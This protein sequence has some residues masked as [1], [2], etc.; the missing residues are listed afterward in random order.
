MLLIACSN[1][2][3]LV[4][5]MNARAPEG[6]GRAAVRLVRGA[7]TLIG[8]VMVESLLLA[9]AGA[10]LGL[11]LSVMSTRAMLGMLPAGG[12]LLMLLPLLFCRFS[13]S[14]LA[15]RFARAR[16]SSGSRRPRKQPGWIFSRRLKQDAGGAQASRGDPSLRGAVPVTAGSGRLFLQVPRQL[17]ANR[18][19]P[20]GLEK[21]ATFPLESSQERLHGSGLC[22]KTMCG[23]I[24][25]DTRRD[26]SHAR[27]DTVP[28][29]ARRRH[30]ISEWGGIG[31]RSGEEHGGG[32]RRRGSWLLG[33]HGNSTLGWAPNQQ[34]RDRFDFSEG[35]RYPTRASSIAASR[36]AFFPMRAPWE[37]TLALATGRK[38]WGLKS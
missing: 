36:N 28:S 38:S 15:S 18:D 33:C 25:K 35:G 31:P 10:L 26:V 7:G 11:A 3:S 20:V 17:E 16:C 24:A 34:D 32:G 22:V 19:R 6:D 29:R 8:H 1:V 27:V 9:F 37:S 2:A 21:L 4:V 12:A 23:R 13:S 5:A 30:A 14:A